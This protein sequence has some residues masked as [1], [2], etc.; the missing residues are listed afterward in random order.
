MNGEILEEVDHFK[1][2]GAI[3]NKEG[4]STQEIKTRLAFYQNMV[5]QQ[6]NNKN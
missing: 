6:Y 2:L 5:Q 4:N 3:I 1:Y